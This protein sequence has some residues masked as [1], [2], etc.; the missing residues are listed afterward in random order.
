MSS[1]GELP[2]LGSVPF[3]SRNLAADVRA[4]VLAVSAAMAADIRGLR[5]LVTTLRAD[6][7]CAGV[8]VLVG[9]RRFT[10]NPRLATMV[11]TDGSTPGALETLELCRD[12]TK[13]R[14]GAG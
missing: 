6:P 9:G 13:D 4:D 14:I 11:G 8:R 12:R 3:E 7:R 2:D 10:I 5:E 1:A